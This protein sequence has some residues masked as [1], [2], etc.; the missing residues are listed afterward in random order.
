[1]LDS[2]W[3]LPLAYILGIFVVGPVVDLARIRDCIHADVIPGANTDVLPQS[4]WWFATTCF[5]KKAFN[6]M[7]TQFDRASSLVARV[8]LPS[9]G[10]SCIRRQSQAQ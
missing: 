6:S 10:F 9:D 8:G 2:I 5:K 7:V 4:N 3:H 1:M